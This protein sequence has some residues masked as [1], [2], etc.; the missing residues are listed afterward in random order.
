MK[1]RASQH[2]IRHDAGYTLLEML[3]ALVVFGLVMAGIAQTF[4]FGLTAWSA[5]TR[6]ATRPEVLA[7]MDAA[8]TQMIVQT[9]PG[10]MTGRADGLA[11]TTTLP[12]GSGLPGGLADAAIVVAPDGDLVLRYTPHPPGIPLE[13]PPAPKVESLAEGVTA[14]NVS[15]LVPQIGA[16]PAWSS[17]W[18]GDGLPLLVKIH[19]QFA[20]GRN[21]PDLVA[22]PMSSAN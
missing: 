17:S 13:P 4:R 10:S 2:K 12:A 15:Y 16:A 8:L 5:T 11:L 20:G 1:R 22:A 6:N 19:L 9:L 7:A 18:S 3:V 21:W 14:L